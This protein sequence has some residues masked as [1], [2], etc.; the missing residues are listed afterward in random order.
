[1]SNQISEEG[2][3]QSPEATPYYED[4]PDLTLNGLNAMLEG[5][6]SACSVE[7]HERDGRVFFEV[8]Y[9]GDDGEGNDT[10]E[11]VAT[12]PVPS[13]DFAPC[14]EATILLMIGSHWLS[15]DFLATKA[16]ESLAKHDPKEANLLAMICLNGL[17]CVSRKG[18]LEQKFG[19]D[20]SA[21][22]PE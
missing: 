3:E 11:V 7:R 10:E 16:L 8:H 14:G 6:D 22:Y 13:L 15:L 4:F 18:W 1:M 19:L 9:F 12:Y 17:R 2:A 21:G 5:N 20:L